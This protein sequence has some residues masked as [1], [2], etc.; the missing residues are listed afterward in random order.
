MLQRTL[1]FLVSTVPWFLSQQHCPSLL[2]LWL[3]PVS[4]SPFKAALGSW[5]RGQWSQVPAQ[6]PGLHK[7][8]PPTPRP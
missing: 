5:D 1:L 2:C 3:G 7:C 6:V 8:H 4:P